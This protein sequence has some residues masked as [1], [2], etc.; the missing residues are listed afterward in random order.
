MYARCQ[1]FIAAKH[2]R[3][4]HQSEKTAA[5]KK[6]AAGADGRGDEMPWANGARLAQQHAR[7]ESRMHLRTRSVVATNEHLSKPQPRTRNHVISS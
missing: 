3:R 6:G 7:K 2:P 5:E 1:Q 4:S